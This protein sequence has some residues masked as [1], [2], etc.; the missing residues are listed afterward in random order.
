VSDP[1]QN[2]DPTRRP[3]DASLDQPSVARVYDAYL[4]GAAHHGA[5]RTFAE[6]V[7]AVLPDVGGLAA[8]NRM[9]LARGVTYAIEQ[10]INQIL[11]IG[12]GVPSIW[13][14]H[15]VA[16]QINPTARV[17]Y[18]D[19]EA[20]AYHA[21]QHATRHDPRLGAL[22]ADVREVDA[23]LTDPVTTGLIDPTRPVAL[24]L[25]LLL[26]FL[27]DSDDPAGVLGRYRDAL[28]AGSCLIIS[29]ATRD[30]RDAAIAQVAARYAEIG[31]PITP[32]SQAELDLMVEGF[33]VVEPGVVHTPLWRPGP[34]DPVVEHPEQSCV[35]AVVAHT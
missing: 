5:D 11:D 19:H 24:V 1:D 17:V 21:L 30:G 26:H 18:V 9:F 13:Q 14:T 29:H 16:H 6:H 15:H 35:Y 12:A 33:E 3:I 4:D 25:G 23:V 2:D 10:G 8:L 32:R 34:D 22:R 20:V 28:M 7:R 31:R 27:P